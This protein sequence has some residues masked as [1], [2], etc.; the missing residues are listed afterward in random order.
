VVAELPPLVEADEFVSQFR[1]RVLSE[2]AFECSD[3]VLWFVPEIGK[4]V[5]SCTKAGPPSP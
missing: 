2:D 4:S 1:G 3:G 5:G